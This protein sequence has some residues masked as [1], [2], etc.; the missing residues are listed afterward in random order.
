MQ[1]NAGIRVPNAESFFKKVRIAILFDTVPFDFMETFGKF[2]EISIFEELTDYFV[3]VGID[4]TRVRRLGGSCRCHVR[5]VLPPNCELQL[6]L[7]DVRVDAF[8]PGVDAA[9][10]VLDLG[11]ALGLEEVDRPGAAATHLAM[12]SQQFVLGQFL[13]TLRQLR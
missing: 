7:R 8:G 4:D 5:H 3:R 9:G 12:H 10:D 2:L 6:I 13:E 1:V 11:V